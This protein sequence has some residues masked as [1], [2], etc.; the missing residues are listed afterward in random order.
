MTQTKPTLL[1]SLPML[2]FTGTATILAFGAT[3]W[4]M[5]VFLSFW[6]KLAKAGWLLAS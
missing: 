2:L 3:A 6:W 4:L 5:G 1:T